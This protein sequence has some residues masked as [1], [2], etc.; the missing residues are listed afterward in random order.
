M[1]VHVLKGNLEKLM[2]CSVTSASFSAAL[3][4]FLEHLEH[5]GSQAEDAR[6]IFSKSFVGHSLL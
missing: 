4:P 6:P 5:L 3:V 2:V 1:E